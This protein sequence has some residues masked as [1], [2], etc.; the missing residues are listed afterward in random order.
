MNFRLGLAVA[1]V[2]IFSACGGP[3]GN[4]GG[5][6]GGSGGGNQDAGQSVGTGTCTPAMADAGSATTGADGGTICHQ[7]PNCAEDVIFQSGS[8]VGNQPTPA[9]GTINDGLYALTAVRTY[10]IGPQNGSI[11]VKFTVL[12]SGDTF[13]LSN[14]SY[15]SGADGR[16][17]TTATFSGA[18]W[19]Q[20]PV[21]PAASGTIARKYTVVSPD[22][23]IDY[24]VQNVGTSS[25]RTVAYEYTR[26]K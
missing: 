21:C 22:Q 13:Y 10:N 9:G 8:D 23:W 7:L 4:D 16:A 25:S 2:T 17:I 18:D 3:A 5:S 24:D 14:H 6:G 26:V 19:T 12:K 15:S 11:K 1:V 20:T